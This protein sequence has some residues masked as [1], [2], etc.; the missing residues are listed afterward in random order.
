MVGGQRRDA[1]ATRRART[2]RRAQRHGLLG[3]HD[4]VLR[5]RP[6]LALPGGEV[7]PH[8]LA[9]PRLRRRR[10][11]RPRSRPRRPAP[12]PGTRTPASPWSPARDFQSVGFTPATASRTRTSPGPG[13]GVATSL[14]RQHVRAAGRAID[15]GQHH[16]S[17]N[18]S[19]GRAYCRARSRFSVTPSPGVSGTFTRPPSITG[20]SKPDRQVVPERHAHA[21]PFQREEVRDRRRHV[22]VGDRADRR[23]DA[24]RRHRD[25]VRVGVVGDPP[26]LQQPA[27]LLRVG[28]GDVDRAALERLAEAVAHVAVLARGDPR[29]GRLR[30][31]RAAPARSPAAP[32]PR[33]TSARAARARARAAARRRPGSASGS[34]RRRRPRRRRRR[35]PPPRARPCSAP[36]PATASPRPCPAWYGVGTSRSNFSALKP[37][38]ATTCLRPRRVQLRRE[39]L[40]RDALRVRAPVLGVADRPA[41]IA[42]GGSC[43]PARRPL[44]HRRVHRV[45]RLA[46]VAVGVHAHRV[47]ETTAEQPV[48]RH[49]VVAGRR[50][51]RARPRSPRSRCRRCPRTSPAPE[52]PQRSFAHRR[53]TSRA[54]SPIS[55][56]ARSRTIAVR[57]GAREALA[58]ARKPLA[59][60]VH[61]HEGPVVVRLDDGGVHSGDPHRGHRFKEHDL[62]T[63]TPMEETAGTTQKQTCARSSRG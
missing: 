26:R 46:R 60:G 2:T 19:P 40:V 21:V 29:R 31:P 53:S 43:A 24:V 15:R 41:A 44:D 7:D 42:S 37:R 57:P 33:A 49:A 62:A 52:Q 36:R 22:H 18:G 58:D 32:G 54:S 50:G 55:S 8:A 63:L 17:K 39:D 35:S 13:D 14:D 38:S 59:F 9:D 6:P 23:R 51:P 30:D 34:R 16:S 5:R 20:P 1:R 27:G 3:R 25:V 56:G 28:R 10:R 48:D 4:R 61:A 45:Q 11:R 47:A 12:A